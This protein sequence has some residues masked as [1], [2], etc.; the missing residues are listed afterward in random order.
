MG[1]FSN[2]QF[3][4]Q[5]QSVR[6]TRPSISCQSQIPFGQLSAC[7]RAMNRSG[8]KIIGVQGLGDQSSL[9]ISEPEKE[10]ISTSKRTKNTE[11]KIEANNNSKES[12]NQNKKASP[13]RRQRRK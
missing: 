4:I 2:R 9:P 8:L 10:K 5:I 1:P 11:S 7:F 13:R 3:T 12:S 6:R